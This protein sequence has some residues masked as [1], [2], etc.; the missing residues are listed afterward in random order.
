[1]SA[2]GLDARI[3]EALGEEPAATCPVFVEMDEATAKRIVDA[4]RW[5]LYGGQEPPGGRKALLITL[6]ALT[7]CLSAHEPHKEA[8]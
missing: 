5:A 1:M 2:V 7:L 4:L 8:V 3:D 6:D